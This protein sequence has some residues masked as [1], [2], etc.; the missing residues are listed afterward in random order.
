M[1]ETTPVIDVVK[2]SEQGECKKLIEACER[3]GCFRIINHSIP[4]T[5]MAEMKK[6]VGALHDLPLEIKKRNT[7]VI[8]GSGY[9]GPSRVSPFFEAMGIYDLGSSH[10]MHNFC[11]QVDASP[12]QSLAVNNGQKMVE[13]LGPLGA[14]FE[15]WLCELKFNKYNFAPEAVGSTGLRMHTDSGVPSHSSR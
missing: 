10:A 11:S 4:A 13:S 9:V 15:D 8:A 2:I 6:V 7:E 1:E 3:W 14:D 5:L 12:Y